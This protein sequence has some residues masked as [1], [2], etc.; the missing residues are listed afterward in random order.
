VVEAIAEE[1]INH[2]GSHDTILS[3]VDEDAF[4]SEG[5]DPSRSNI[6]VIDLVTSAGRY[7]IACEIYARAEQLFN[8]LWPRENSITRLEQ[9]SRIQPH[10]ARL[11]VGVESG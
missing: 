8:V 2:E 7:G 9:L 10:I 11:F 1:L 6:S 3:I 5:T 4:G